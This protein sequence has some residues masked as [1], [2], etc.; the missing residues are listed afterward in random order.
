M[1]DTTPRRRPVVLA[2][3]TPRMRLDGLRGRSPTTSAM[4]AVVLADPMSSPATS[5]ST[6]IGVWRSPGHENEDRAPRRGLVAWPDQLRREISPPDGPASRPTWHEP[7]A[8]GNG[9]VPLDHQHGQHRPT[10]RP[11][12]AVPLAR[13]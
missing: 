10:E 2:C 1:S 11:H 3:P 6:F 4:I 13:A 5:L 8:S 9:A 12:Q 7:A